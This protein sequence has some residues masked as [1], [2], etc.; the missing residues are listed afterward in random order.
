MF[1]R[2]RL[3]MLLEPFQIGRVKLRN[4]IVRAPTSMDFTDTNEYVT[5]RVKDY[6]E[7]LAKGGVGLIITDGVHIDSRASKGLHRLVIDDDKFI[8]GLRELAE[9]IHGHGCP[10]FLQ[11]N[12]PGPKQSQKISGSQPV[13][14]TSLDPDEK[15]TRSLD[16]ARALSIAEIEELMDKFAKGAARAQE[17]GFDGVEIHGAHNY[18]INSFLSRVWNKRQDVYGCQDLESRARF[19]VEIIRTI[20]ERVGQDFP[21]G[22]RFNGGEWGVEKGITSDESQGLG[23]IFEGAGADFLHISGFGYG[24]YYGMLRPEQILY[25]EP[26]KEIIPLVKKI[27]K[28][29][30]F[31]TR[32][33]AIKRVVSIPVIGVGRLDPQLG[34]WLLRK[35]KVDLIAFSRRLLADPELPNKVAAGRLADIAPCTACLHCANNFSLHKPVVCRINAVL[36]REQEYAIR[37]AGNKKKVLVVGGGPAGME[38]ARVAALRGHEVILYEKEHKLGGL[39]SLAALIKGIDIEDFPALIR[40]LK[41]QITELGVKVRLGKKVD[42]RT[43]EEIKPDVVILAT[44]GRLTVPEIRGTK[45]RRVMTS[46]ELH[47]KAKIPLMLF[48]PRLLR[49]LTRFWLPIRKR[50]V[51]LGGLIHGC[52]TAE[53][54]IKRGRKVTIV[55]TSDQLGTGIIEMHKER[56]LPWLTTEGVNMLSGV[57]YVEITDQG[58]I[59][60]DRQGNK[61]AIQADTIVIATPPVPNTELVNNLK[62]KVPEVH[63]IGDAKDPRLIIDAIADGLHVGRTI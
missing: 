18:L 49:W 36:G 11:L 41:T 12:H 25:P 53:F 54:L 44:G 61:Q 13:A 23:K 15:V 14:S 16:P 9:V 37:S 22:I 27:K 46:A 47:Q 38:A 31:V 17:A 58:V 30:V 39:L 20:K 52:E 56:L 33:E 59:I 51:I 2:S 35:G 32:A 55:E 21:V 1:Y 42:L 29:G 10:T 63:I 24:A 3:R 19:I 5:E 48:G 6:F 26:A 62:G 50:V 8:P 43:I 60:I 40:Y 4:R 57:K 28:P 45:N 7:I 34:E